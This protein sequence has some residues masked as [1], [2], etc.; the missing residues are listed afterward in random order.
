MAHAVPTPGAVR[1][2]FWCLGTML[3]RQPLARR[4][5]GRWPVGVM[6]GEWAISRVTPS[7]GN[8][9]GDAAPDPSQVTPSSRINTMPPTFIARRLA[10]FGLAL[11][12]TLATMVLFSGCG[13]GV[14]GGGGDAAAPNAVPPTNSTRFEAIASSA[15]T[16]SLAWQAVDSAT[17][18]SVERRSA[19][20]VWQAVGSVDA[21]R[22]AFHDQGLAAKTAYSY[23]LV[24]AGLPSVEHSVTTTDEMPLATAPGAAQGAAWAKILVDGGGEMVSP[25]GSVTLALP[26]GALPAGSSVSAQPV[27]N[28]APDGQGSAL[29]LR[30]P[31]RPALPLRL[32]LRYEQAEADAADAMRI[33]VQRA[34]GTWISLPLLAADAA[35]RTLTSEL[36]AELL[37]APVALLAAPADGLKAAAEVAVDFTIVRYIAVRLS[38]PAARVQ[39][40]KGLALVPYARVRGY[41]TTISRC[42]EEGEIQLCFPMPVLETREIPFTNAKAGY[43]RLWLVNN[44][45]GGGGAW[46]I[47]A[48]D[49]AVGARYTAPPRVP[50]PRFA[51][52]AFVSRDLATGRS[53][54]LVSNIEIWDEAW[55]GTMNAMLGPSSAG[56]TLTT[57][58]NVSWTLDEAVSTATLKVYRGSGTL[59]TAITDNNCTA[60]VLPN[61]QPLSADTR[62]VALEVDESALPMTYKARLITFWE[63]TVS[64]ACPKGHGSVGTRMAG[65]GWEVQG[66]VNG[67]GLVIEGAATDQ[68]GAQ[69]EWTFTR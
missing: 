3:P 49:G 5:E 17:V 39:V 16:A 6:R 64:G 21:R 42:S 26:A 63:A 52:V 67:D 51:R 68:N 57:R 7:L 56:T 10:C 36:P 43:E 34:D 14:G 30:L 8:L 32:T 35:A 25:D 1:S 38:P 2:V 62:L 48:A 29:K 4:R 37:A 11:S 59:N 41:S 22:G 40:K 46:G 69:I 20:G 45:P 53:V 33:A 15:T 65:Y 27:S 47:V 9:A 24:A 31:A 66:H 50:Q 23:R 13:G 18:W 54:K 55:S 44:V 61:D 19:T 12:M 28:T 60:G 58:A